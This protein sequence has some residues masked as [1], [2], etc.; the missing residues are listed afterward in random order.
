MSKA[1]RPHLIQGFQHIS[2]ILKCKWT[3]AILDAVRRGVTRPSQIRRELPGLAAKVL[4]ERTKKLER[5]GVLRKSVYA[6]IPPRVE[7]HLTDRGESLI[8]LIER[9]VEFVE[10]EWTEVK[11]G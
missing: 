8:R 6:E 4:N 9:I 5:Y 7:Y 1:G 11:L 2:E 10:N 3:L